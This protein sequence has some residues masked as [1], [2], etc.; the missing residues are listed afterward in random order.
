MSDDEE[1]TPMLRNEDSPAN[2]TAPEAMPTQNARDKPSEPASEFSSKTPRRV[3]VY[4]LQGDDWSDNG[5]GY[6]TGL[7]DPDTHKPC[8]LVYNELNEDEIILKSFLEGSI[9]YQRQQETLIV[10]TDLA[11][12]DLA[13]S[14]QENEGCADLCD[15]IVRVQQENLSPMISLYFVI[16]IRESAAEGPRELTE[17]VTGPIS[18][19]PDKLTRE[20]LDEF[21]DIINQGSNS[22]YTRTS[23]L[24]FVVESNYLRVMYALLQDLEQARD[25]PGLHLLCEI[26]KA[27]LVYNEAQI[28]EEF[29][30]NDENALA[31]VGMLEY[32]REYPGF[33]A[34]H[35]E[36]LLDESN[37]R[38][39]IS[40]PVPQEAGEMDVFR[41]DFILNYVRNVVLARSVDDQ[42]LNTLMLMIYS[43]QTKLLE[44][45]QD[46]VAN[47]NF[48][49]R[50]FRLYSSDR[51]LSKKRDGVLMLHQ[52][53]LKTK[54]HHVSQ[55]LAFYSC[56]VNAGLLKM[57]RFA[58]N[59]LELNIRIPGTELLVSLIEQNLPLLNLSGR[60]ESQID[61][62]DP[63]IASV[64]SNEEGHNNKPAEPLKL[65]LIGD[66]SMMMTLSNLLYK[67]ESPAIRVQAFEAIKTILGNVGHDNF[68]GPQDTSDEAATRASLEAFYKDVAPVLFGP[69]IAMSKPEGD[70]RAFLAEDPLLYQHLCD[71]VSYC[72]GEHDRRIFNAFFLGEDVIKGA[73]KLLRL[74]VK[75]ILKL[76]VLRCFKSLLALGDPQIVEYVL[77]HSLMGAFF[78]FFSSVSQCNNLANSVCLDLLYVLVH[79]TVRLQRLIYYI[80]DTYLPFLSTLNYSTIAADIS[81]FGEPDK[82]DAT[83]TSI[84]VPI[85]T[86]NKI[87]N[88]SSPFEAESPEAVL[89]DDE[90]ERS[91]KKRPLAQD[92]DDEEYSQPMFSK[93]QNELE[94]RQGN[95]PN[96]GLRFGSL[97]EESN[98]QEVPIRP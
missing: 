59:D 1:L 44:F 82:K 42:T 16:P 25:L 41:R 47:D 30:K 52:Y 20:N 69:F 31:V 81:N 94:R 53:T 26:T 38:K 51:P 4:L 29:F 78:E 62:L 89:R 36:Y 61:E 5:T 98:S 63:P 48:L 46:P 23:I 22:Q 40:V 86:G 72:S 14:F 3:K 33:K 43:N 56:L 50:L 58:L 19:P 24:N 65:R 80:R 10:W 28:F 35:R 97:G 2:T 15:F 12:K 49:E 57:V 34:C 92:D 21:A 83:A 74:P 76:G 7:I 60:D 77:Q 75:M 95:S 84:D 66:T 73:M 70:I 37:Y 17:L 87:D 54:S 45:L 85:Q 79:R 93:V 32:D 8:F 64:L 18:Y 27:L 9:Q 11:G 6:C 68:E 71:L 67:D 55:R 39:V 91:E 13:L 90:K 88:P 96:G